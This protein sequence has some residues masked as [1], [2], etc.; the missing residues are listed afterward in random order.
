MESP[1]MVRQIISV[2]QDVIH[3]LDLH[4]TRLDV[5]L[6]TSGRVHVY[7]TAPEFSGKTDTERDLMIWPVLE[8]K[9]PG[10]DLLRLSV[11][12]LMAPEEEAETLNK[13]LEYPN[14][15][16]GKA[17]AD[18]DNANGTTTPYSIFEKITAVFN[19]IIQERNLHPTRLEFELTPYE[20]VHIY[21]EAPEFSGKTSTER[22]LMIWPFLERCLPQN[23]I[24]HISACVLLEPE[25]EAIAAEIYDRKLQTA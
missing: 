1:E 2:F 10:L 11:C 14:K 3:E 25:E 17:S 23:V 4:P 9:L 19:K 15:N 24:M 20:T 8:K 5:E 16:N 13:L 22:D 12:M 7:L 6:T 21:V 18:N